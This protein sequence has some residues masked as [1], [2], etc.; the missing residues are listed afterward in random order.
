[1]THGATRPT[2]RLSLDA[3]QALWADLADPDAARARRA[4]WTLAATS[5]QSVPLLRDC[6]R[7]TPAP[8]SKRL[9]RLIEDLDAADF[10]VRQKAYQELEKLGPHAE[11]AL[12]KCLEGN[13][14]LEIRKRLEQLLEAVTYSREVFRILRAMEVLEQIGTPQARQ[15]LENLAADAPGTRLKQEAQATLDRLDRARRP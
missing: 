1:L 3:F 12:R 2:T 7:P 15:V 11:L 13:P 10:K 14:S 9:T 6:L 4:V 8:N 5:D